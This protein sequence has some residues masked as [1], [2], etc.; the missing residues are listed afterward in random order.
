MPDFLLELFSEEMPADAQLPASED[1]KKSII[2]G[3]SNELISYSNAVSFSTP[4]RLCVFVEGLAPVSEKKVD[5]KRGPKLGAPIRAIEGFASSLNLKVEDLTIKEVEK[6]SYYFAELHQAESK[7]TD[8]ASKI[9]KEAI[10]TLGW[11]KSM[12]WGNSKIKWIRPLRSILCIMTYEDH[13]EVVS[14]NID[15]IKASNVTWGHRFMCPEK[16][17]VNCFESYKDQLRNRYVILDPHERAEIIWTDANNLAFSQGLRIIKDEDLLKEVAGLVEWPSVLMGEIA[18]KYLDLPLEVLQTSMKVHQKF[19]SVIND[20]SNKIEKFIT[21]ANVA[22]DDNGRTIIK[23]NQKV[24]DARLADGKFFFENDLKIAKEGGSAWIEN[25]N[26]VI[27]HG[28]LGSLSDRV[29]RINRLALKLA[30]YFNISDEKIIKAVNFSKT[31]LCSEMVYEFPELQGVMGKYYAD[32]ANYD[33]EIAL[34]ILEH[35]QPQGPNDEIPSKP[36]S[37]VLAIADKLDLLSCFWSID[38]RPTGSKD[39]YALR[40]AAI[41]VIRLMLSSGI[42]VNLKEI[43]EDRIA[44]NNVPKDDIIIFLRDRLKVLLRDRGIRYDVIEACFNMSKSDDFVIL[45]EKINILNKFLKTKNGIKLLEC[46]K[47]ANNIL[48]AEEKKDGVKYELDPM[49]E[50]MNNSYEKIL[51]TTLK[52]IKLEIE[53]LFKRKDFESVM[54]KTSRLLMPIDEFFKEVKVNDE[55]QIVRRNRLCLL[56]NVKKICCYL[57]DLTLIQDVNS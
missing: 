30:P 46:F 57:G 11:K 44:K 56:Y 55:S 37:V 2:D 40:R 18:Q 35:Y 31:D 26:Q 49:L 27:F 45:E 32:A 20:K 38:E 4:Q 43:L 1:L 12:R 8:L 51:F 13:S 41:G 22:S 36:L 17:T 6:G 25:L 52:E 39:P 50:Y 47:R 16:F 23:G 53:K 28:K 10:L 29:K 33:E 15:G 19:F 5:I 54:L 48:V 3:F 34:A 14:V 9:V 24:L 21:V 7:V 42:N